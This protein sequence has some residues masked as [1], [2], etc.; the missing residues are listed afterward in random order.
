ME[1]GW[2]VGGTM[3]RGGDPIIPTSYRGWA[4]GAISTVLAGRPAVGMT[5]GFGTMIW[6]GI[7]GMGT[8]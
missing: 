5:C 1:H 2:V 7:G 3:E 6:Q 8:L 4:Y